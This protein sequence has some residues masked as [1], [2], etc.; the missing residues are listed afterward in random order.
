MKKL[1][2][3]LISALSF[4][5]HAGVVI[6]NSVTGSIINNFNSQ[7]IGNVSG[8]LFDTGAIYGERFD[9]QTL[10]VVGGFDVLSGNPFAGLTLLPNATTASNIGILS[11]GAGNVAYGDINNSIGEGALS[12]LLDF[13]SDLFAFDVVG[14][15]GGGQIIAQFFDL[16][17]NI[18]GS[19]SQASANGHFGFR[20]TSGDLI[21]GVSITNT[22]P[23]GI[24]YDNVSFTDT[25]AA[26]PEPAT[27]ALLGLS[28]LGLG[29]ARRK[30]KK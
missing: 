17:G 12:V 18:I 15:D 19:I 29:L 2:L 28:L 14:A 8:L 5:V 20:A 16:T 30:S 1:A 26:V 9:G 22:D 27:A 24:G 21:W 6:D 13:A 23:A 7:S 10:T 25:P 11:Y 4:S 3:A